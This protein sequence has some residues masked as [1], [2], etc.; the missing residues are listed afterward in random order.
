MT[1][2]ALLDRPVWSCVALD[3][4]RGGLGAYNVVQANIA[5]TITQLGSCFYF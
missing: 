5:P 3:S 4:S 1:I 2:I